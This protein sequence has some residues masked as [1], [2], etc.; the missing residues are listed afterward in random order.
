MNDKINTLKENFKELA[1]L[2]ERKLH[3]MLKDLKDK[4]RTEN[5]IAEH[6]SEINESIKRIS[7]LDIE[8]NYLAQ[9]LSQEEW[10]KAERI[11]VAEVGQRLRYT[12]NREVFLKN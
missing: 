6:N 7:E 10:N 12:F 5:E 8:I 11:Y 3:L 9:E 4:V 1:Y 2:K